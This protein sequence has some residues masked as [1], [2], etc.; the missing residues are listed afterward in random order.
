MPDNDVEVLSERFT[1]HRL[2]DEIEDSNDRSRRLASDY[3]AKVDVY[4]SRVKTWFLDLA[5]KDMVKGTSPADY[6]AV[7]IALAYIEGVQQYWEGRGPKARESGTF[8]RTSASRVF[9][10]ASFSVINR[11]WKSVRNGLFHTGFT[12]GPIVLSHAWK[13]GE[14]EVDGRYLMIHPAKFVNAVVVDFE[15]YVHEL[16]T[17]P[18]GTL[19]KNFET[20]WTIRWEES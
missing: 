10:R 20:L 19:A 13:R 6:V 11:L 15:K 12:E 17:N 4:E 18:S 2:T 14:L 16:R 7:S 3:Q 8:F 9:A 1:Y 5:M